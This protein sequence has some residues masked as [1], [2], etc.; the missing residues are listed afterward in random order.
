M[1]DTEIDNALA[2]RAGQSQKLRMAWK[3]R[4]IEAGLPEL[5]VESLR[6]WQMRREHA[7]QLDDDVVALR[8]GRD[9]LLVE[10]VS[11][12]GAIASGLKTVGYQALPED[13]VDKIEG[14]RRFIE[15]AVLWEK[16]T[17]EAGAAHSTYAKALQKQ[18][19][20]QLKINKVISEAEIQLEHHTAALQE[21]HA[22]IISNI[23]C[24][25][26]VRQSSARRA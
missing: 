14:L 22:K 11:A 2:V 23:Q 10:V 20:E 1:V 21:W 15:H 16:F 18:R 19:A 5:D 24:F 6:D 12:S 26:R 25:S 7:L 8:S 17:T 3:R 13:G 4:L 9:R